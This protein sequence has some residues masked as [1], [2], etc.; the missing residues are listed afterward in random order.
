MSSKPDHVSFVEKKEGGRE[1]LVDVSYANLRVYLLRLYS[2]TIS[3][4]T[5]KQWSELGGYT[6]EK[7]AEDRYR[8]N[9][10]ALS[11][12]EIWIPLYDPYSDSI[13][14]IHRD[15]LFTRIFK[16]HYRF[17]SHDLI[18]HLKES[19]K[20]ENTARIIEF[21]ENYDLEILEKTYHSAVYLHSKEVGKEL[22]ICKRPSFSHCFPHLAPWYKRSEVINLALNLGL[23]KPDKTYYDRHKLRELCRQVR[24]NDIKAV[25]L[26]QHRSHVLD[27][28]GV[29]I[30][31]YYTLNGAFFMNRYLRTLARPN[32]IRNPILESCILHMW[33]LIRTS[34]C[35]DKEY[36][37]YRFVDKDYLSHL[38]VGDIFYDPGFVSATRDPFYRAQHYQFGFILLK[39][40]VPKK[41]GLVLSLE[42]W[43]H[44]PPEQEM[45]LAP[46]TGIK[47]LKKDD[48]APFYHIDATFEERVATRYEF[49]IVSSSEPKIPP[50]ASDPPAPEPL[51]LMDVKDE[52]SS[53]GLIQERIEKFHQGSL[54][55]RG[56]FRA[57]IGSHIFTIM[58]EWYDST[59]AYKDFY[60]HMNRNGFSMY[61]FLESDPRRIMFFLEI[62]E[63]L[64]EL[65]V[66]WYFKWSDDSALM[67]IVSEDE[68]VSFLCQLAFRL[69]IQRVIIYG[70]YKFCH[71]HAATGTIKGADKLPIEEQSCFYGSYRADVYE[72][73][74]GGV[75]RFSGIGEVKAQFNWYYL[76]KWKN[77]S[78]DKI[79]KDSD[80]DQF[81]QICL[82]EGHKTV[83]DLYI[84]T[85]EK[86]C[87]DIAVLE[88]KIERLY[89]GVQRG[90]NP[91]N[92]L[93]WTVEPGQ[94]LFSKGILN[95]L[96][97]ISSNILPIGVGIPEIDKISQKK[98]IVVK[99][100]VRE[101]EDKN[102]YRL[103]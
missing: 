31:Q 54:D 45:V 24:A 17:P 58:T 36:V 60:A 39:I 84:A 69:G 9:A 100:S 3:L 35:F 12:Y 76:D 75:K 82:A 4:P 103:E 25:I 47:L 71:T 59:I 6:R 37:L 67:S 68:F 43:S 53:D 29:Y 81:F 52:T 30:V 38:E 41:S 78:V 15:N 23:I 16:D 102:R 56:H 63:E 34:P 57:K 27:R 96:P 83:A 21:I 18:E 50:A 86:H 99:K 22:V 7:D 72:Y 65:H 74:K 79:L 77:E 11:Q 61:G 73:L 46:Y 32:S 44:F 62:I 92:K 66:N 89:G 10:R 51:N 2:G 26:L 101:K 48:H 85:V 87:S 95:Y 64:Q 8:D 80:R 20:D 1:K 19:S 98:K 49:E 55:P 5:V 94:Y 90:F 42:P 28:D 93:F 70:R 14:L 91:L 97:K 40:R 88:S 13:Y 33:N